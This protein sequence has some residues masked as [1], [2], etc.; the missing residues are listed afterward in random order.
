M[1]RLTHV[2]T[3][4]PAVSHASP[5]IYSKPLEFL[6]QR[7]A[8]FSNIGLS[9]YTLWIGPVTELTCR[10]MRAAGQLG[11][12]VQHKVGSGG[13]EGLLRLA[14]GG[15]TLLRGEGLILP[16]AQAQDGAALDH[17]HRPHPRR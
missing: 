6:L 1:S 8:V 2:G 11:Q 7:F 16:L 12:V 14:A 13:A 4:S 15:P 10:S 3:V 9:A 17:P 5:A